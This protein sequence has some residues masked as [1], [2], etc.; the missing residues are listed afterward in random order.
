[1]RRNV[2][3]WKVSLVAAVAVAALVPTVALAGASRSS[4]AVVDAAKAAVAK[5]AE[6]NGTYVLPEAGPN[7]NPAVTGK[8]V[9]VIS[10]GLAA[11]ACA[12]PAE[13][14]AKAAKTLGWKVT[15]F[16]GKF[17]PADYN[18]GI[19]QAIAA[20]ADGIIVVA[21]DCSNAKGALQAARKAGIKIVGAYAYDCSDPLIKGPS[22]FDATINSNGNPDEWAS[23][24]AQ[25]RAQYAIALTNGG[26][27]VLSLDQPEFLVA[28]WWTNAFAAGLA[29]CTTCKLLAHVP[30]TGNDL[31]NAGRS[32]QKLATALLQHPDTNVLFV[33]SDALQNALLPSIRAAKKRNPKLIVIGN[34]G[35]AA[36]QELIRQGVT[37]AAVGI[38]VPWMGWSAADA[39]NRIFN[40]QT[41]IPNQGLGYHLITKANVPAAGTV[42]APTLNYQAAFKKIWAAKG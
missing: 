20:K 5:A 1:M 35:F 6:P 7:G 19:R 36:T 22:L 34:E 17:S 38:Y 42:W 15:V 40:G 33:T 14:V 23:A 32:S 31:V 10:C 3:S 8:N 24:N 41:T 4:D 26:A 16:D 28:K 9:Y 30:Y 12:K 2:S 18:T 11:E 21:I 37:S 29:K 25:L 39:L 27:K 13:E